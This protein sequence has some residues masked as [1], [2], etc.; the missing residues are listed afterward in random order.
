MSVAVQGIRSAAAALLFALAACGGGSDE[1]SGGGGSGGGSEPATPA[2][3][4]VVG[5]AGGTVLGPN[6]T[7][8]E[9]PPGALSAGTT[10]SVEQT[11]AASP[12]LPAG[13]S[14][15][16]QMFALTPHGTAFSVPAT[17]TLPFDGSQVPAGMMPQV[18]KTN[19]RNQ[20]VP[21]AGATFGAGVVTA[22]VTGFS[23]MQVVV[24]LTRDAPRR[25]YKFFG[26]DSPS[27]VGESNEGVLDKRRFVSPGGAFDNRLDGDTT[28]A[29]EVF[30]SADGVTF[31]AGSEA[32][33]GAVV[34]EQSQSFVKNVDSATLEFVITAAAVEA[35]DFNRT[36]GT[37]ECPFG[38]TVSC[39]PIQAYAEFEMELVDELG[40]L[41]EDENEREIFSAGTS[42]SIDGHTVNWGMRVKKGVESS[43]HLLSRSLLATNAD[44]LGFG[45]DNNPHIRL[46]K[47]HTVRVDLSRVKTGSTFWINSLL[48]KVTVD[49]RQR[50]SGVGAFLRNPSKIGGTT[51]SYTGLTPTGLPRPPRKARLPIRCATGPDPA[52]GVLAFAAARFDTM[53]PN[54]G[55]ESSRVVVVTRPPAPSGLDASFGSGGKV[56]TP[57]G[58]SDSA[59][60]LQSD[61]RIVMVG[62]STDAF[63]LARY[64]ADGSLDMGFGNAGLVS[65]DVV[66]GGI[67]EEV[68]RAVAIQAD[69]KI[70]VGRH[71]RTPGG[72]FAFVLARYNANGSLDASFEAAGPVVGAVS[73]RAFALALQ[74]DGCIVAARDDPVGEDFRLARFKA[75]GSLDAGFGTRGQVTTDIAGGPDVARNI[76]LQ[77]TGAIVVSSDPFG[78]NPGTAVARYTAAG[79]LDP[80]FGNGGTS[81]LAGAAV[82]QGLALQRDGK[83]VLVG[84]LNI[85]SGATASTDFA[86]MRLNADGSPDTTFGAAGTVTTA[87]SAERDG[88]LA[89]ALQTDGRIVVAGHTSN[90]NS[91]FA[92]ARYDSNGTLDTSFGNGRGVLTVDF[93]RFTDIGENVLVQPDGKIVVSGQA[94]NSVGG[95]GLARINP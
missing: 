78:N 85:G 82:G 26:T 15:V 17:L 4:A 79:N 86:L 20:W 55:A 76:A 13:F 48:H 31:W 50:E 36:P 11:S 70:V 41:L 21:V 1:G 39:V 29:L 25:I 75:D 34:L 57:F 84:K 72:P 49:R 5:A 71:V 60:A 19:E 81:M 59:M 2:S 89:V 27:E 3:G 24:P 18:M 67:V 8:V 62:G 52:A 69:G 74:P 88:A 7:K 42:L 40:D 33:K 87:V 38:P 64:N 46:V 91:N 54:G 68:A 66:A 95:Y 44:P 53:E 10:T 63:V 56:T 65:T 12:S 23:F 32:G 83:L 61:G 22:G 30:S 9:I 28:N 6:G 94:Q 73:G 93:F 92:V 47:S 51:A 14:A 37:D 80:S 90:I 43:S 77:P 58:G 16:G 45:I 35:I